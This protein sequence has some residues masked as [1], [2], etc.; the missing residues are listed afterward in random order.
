[1][2]TKLLSRARPITQCYRAPSLPLIH[3][4]R[5]FTTTTTWKID[6]KSDASYSQPAEDLHQDVSKEEKTHYDKA[7][8]E[9]KGKQIRTPWHRDG[10]DTPPVSRQRSAGAMTKGESPDIGTKV[11]IIDVVK[12]NC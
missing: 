8:A 6:V 3:A 10:S 12:G 1:M 9:D 2:T 5:G 7:V 11:H 4:K